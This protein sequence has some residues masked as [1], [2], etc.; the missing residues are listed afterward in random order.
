MLKISGRRA[1][2][3]VILSCM[4]LVAQA[5]S[6]SAAISGFVTAKND[7][8]VP[9]ATVMITNIA[10]GIST[11][12]HTNDSGLYRISGLTPGTYRM[13][14]QADGFKSVVRDGIELHLE[15]EVSVNYSLELGSVTETVT[16]QGD[17][18][19]I[20]SESPVVSQVIQGR[21]VEDTPLNGRNVMNLVAL[22]PGVVPQG[23]T[24]GG[25]TQNQ[26]GGFFTNSFG[27]NNYQ[28]SGG[29]AGQSSEYLDGA[30]LNILD[31]HTS[32]LV[33]T[34]DSIQEFRVET[35][36]V[37]PRYGAFGGGVISFAT[38]S[39]ANDVHGTMYEYFR[40]TLL[41]AND[42]FNNL[43][44]L[45]RTKLNQNQFGGT[46]GG[47]IK[48]DKAFA[49]FSYEGFREA[50][51]VPNTGRVPTPAELSGNFSA[52]TPIY[53]PTTGH[54]FACNGV[55]NVICPERIDSTANVMATV[56]HYWPTPS[57]NQS[58]IN[59][60]RNGAAG[61]S[62]NQY[63][64]RVDWQL[65]SHKLFGR[66]TYWSAD[67]KPTQFF[68]GT[69]GPSSGPSVTNATQ[70]VVLGDTDVINNSTILDL[71][72]SYLRYTSVVTPAATDVD[73][74]TF[75]PFYAAIQNQVS[76]REYP[77]VEVSGTVSQ[78]FSFLNVTNGGPYNN[79]ALSGTLTRTVGKHIL[80]AGGEARRQDEHLNQTID[81]TGLHIFA[82]VFT[83]CSTNC[84]T[85]TGTPAPPT[86]AGSGATPIA[87]FMLGQITASEGFTEVFIPTAV[88]NYGGV[89]AS[90]VFQLNSR[91]TLT[92]GLRWEMPG[93]FTEK[94]NRNAVLLPQLAN[95]L[96][97]VS[98]PAYPSRSD[99]DAHR[100][101]F[102]PRAGFA[103]KATPETTLRGGY[104]L[105]FLP[106][107]TDFTAAPFGSPINAATTFVAFGAQ[108]SSPLGGSTTLIQ[109]VGRAYNGT[110][111]LGQSIAGRIPD[112]S[113]PYMYQW[114]AVVEQA[115]SRSAV[116]QLGYVGARGLHLPVG[117]Y[118]LNINQIPD[119]YVG[120]PAAQLSQSL[121]PYPEYQSVGAYSYYGGYNAYDSLQA[122]LSKQFASGGTLLANYTWSKF[123]GNSEAT[124]GFVESYTS[125]AIQDNNNLHGEY[126][127]LSFDTPHRLVVSYVVDLPF[128]YGQRYLAAAKGVIGYLV[129]DWSVSGISSFASGFPLAISAV[130]N[131][132]S[133]VYGAGTIR[134]NYVAGCGK[135]VGGGIVAHAQ[136]A[137]PLL[138][139]A[140]FTQPGDTSFGN[141]PRVDSTVRA[142]GVD[143]WDFSL[144]KKTK[145]TERVNVQFRAELFNTFN[146][147]Q[148]G[149]PDTSS[150]TALFGVVSTQV[151]QPRL[152]QFSLR[153]N[154]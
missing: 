71:R 117:Q 137:S 19:V 111:F 130:A 136:A 40:N 25:T 34:Q 93:G 129:S 152:F 122:T 43:F 24:A 120:L 126:S 4:T 112:Q 148:F 114:N 11:T 141:E 131:T 121:R 85:P 145:L 20:E 104:S 58:D 49:F 124:T 110:Q 17:T 68:F 29:L 113:F 150:G 12:A 32:S 26:L 45:P 5:Q 57:T 143:N 107:D 90:D 59:Y 7:A 52:D 27:W 82:G 54:Q 138:N 78:P 39:G 101:L 134:P 35:S 105:V 50:L 128:G 41:D 60:A 147:V 84:T 64:G 119:Q 18:G 36:V 146:R 21:Q 28:V 98:S 15:D 144:A 77:N 8:T 55:L 51:G 115:L 132:L 88:S 87:D 127:L 106:Q 153:T 92:Y 83:G 80:S 69:N 116:M 38:R 99:L 61:S 118:G 33:P 6:T 142:Q 76:Y 94:H 31:G 56:T 10:S 23:A 139:Q 30:P 133:N 109:P 2:T 13:T 16:V 70:Q 108:L 66:Y 140:C 37:N 44:G 65:R 42:F 91:L 96:V 74:S 22:T 102:S 14:I 123:M 1:L 89:F 97:L 46:V 3:L 63:I 47:P 9:N 95:P 62:N 73:L 149:P 86:P 72:G 75:G 53:D 67:Q 79:Y 154:F 151:N 48:R 81:P 103:F 135:S 100:A 125:G